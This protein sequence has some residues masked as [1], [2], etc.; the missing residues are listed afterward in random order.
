MTERILLPLIS[1]PLTE[2]IRL[3]NELANTCRTESVGLVEFASNISEP[4]AFPLRKDR[5]AI[6]GQGFD[7]STVITHAI[8]YVVG[9][10]ALQPVLDRKA[11]IASRAGID[12][13]AILTWLVPPP[14]MS[15]VT[16]TY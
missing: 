2:Q 9:V 14:G 11:F 13:T 15:P 16:A 7:P 10:L 1:G 6:L 4:L 12:A 3:F 8:I 5:L